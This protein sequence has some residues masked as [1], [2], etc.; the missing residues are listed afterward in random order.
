MAPQV[1]GDARHQAKPGG[2]PGVTG[3]LGDG[4]PLERRLIRRGHV[5]VGRIQQSLAHVHLGLQTFNP[6]LRDRSRAPQVAGHGRLIRWLVHLF[7]ASRPRLW[8]PG[9]SSG[10]AQSDTGQPLRLVRFAEQFVLLVLG[11]FPVS[12]AAR[13]RPVPAGA[14]AATLAVCS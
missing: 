6:H 11:V 1:S 9:R 12:T 3:P 13:P 4:Q 14:H 5:V 10:P 2:E 7:G 8:A